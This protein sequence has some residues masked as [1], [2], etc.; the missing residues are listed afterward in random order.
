MEKCAPQYVFLKNH[1]VLFFHW[2]GPQH[3]YLIKIA[4]CKVHW[5]QF[6]IK[7]WVNEISSTDLGKRGAPT[8]SF[9][10]FELVQNTSYVV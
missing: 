9:V 6:I 10:V 8:V 1:F 7:L 5:M 4:F 2:S 3:V